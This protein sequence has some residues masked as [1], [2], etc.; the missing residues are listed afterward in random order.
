MTF[1]QGKLKKSYNIKG[2]KHKK[3]KLVQIKSGFK[4]VGSN[5]T[6]C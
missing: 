5:P 4:K 3:G 1:L 2:V 6:L